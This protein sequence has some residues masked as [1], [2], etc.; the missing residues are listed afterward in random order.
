MGRRVTKQVA[1]SKA[2]GVEQY[3]IPNRRLDGDY[4]VGPWTSYT[5]A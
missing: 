2:S 4:S 1:A 3:E 5:S